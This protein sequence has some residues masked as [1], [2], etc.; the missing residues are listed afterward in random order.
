V[1]GK[2]QSFLCIFHVFFI[3]YLY[4]ESKESNVEVKL[5]HSTKGGHD[6]QL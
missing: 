4:Q 5:T 3:L 2:W 6:S 1:S